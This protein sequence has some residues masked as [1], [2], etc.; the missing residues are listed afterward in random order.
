[1]TMKEREQE[2]VL[3]AIRKLLNEYKEFWFFLSGLILGYLLHALA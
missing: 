3:E 1:M 2:K